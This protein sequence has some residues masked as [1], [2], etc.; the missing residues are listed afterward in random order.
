MFDIFEKL[1]AGQSDEI[2]VV[3]TMN[4]E[5]F[6]WKH[7]SLIGNDQERQPNFT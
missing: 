5:N 4:W 3:E 7:L 2:H 1:I 6:L